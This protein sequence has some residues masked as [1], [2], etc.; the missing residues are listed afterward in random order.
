MANNV[1]KAF[2]IIG[3]L[4]IGVGVTYLLRDLLSAL[5]FTDEMWIGLGVLLTIS[6]GTSLYFM[7]KG[8]GG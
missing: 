1:Q 8:S 6:A 2:A 4:V 3:G 5:E 7:T